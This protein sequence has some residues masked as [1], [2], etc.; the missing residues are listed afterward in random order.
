MVAA[1]A[2]SN[3]SVRVCPHFAPSLLAEP[4]ACISQLIYILDIKIPYIIVWTGA[5]LQLKSDFLSYYILVNNF[6]YNLINTSLKS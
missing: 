1:S 2:N 6:F 4:H 5:I 3:A